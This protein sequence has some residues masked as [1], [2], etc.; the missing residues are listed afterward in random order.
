MTEQ[1]ALQLAADEIMRKDMLEKSSK[2]IAG[3]INRETP[4]IVNAQREKRIQELQEQQEAHIKVYKR[5]NPLIAKEINEILGLE[6]KE[7][8]EKSS[9]DNVMNKIEFSNK[10][11]RIYSSFTDDASKNV[12]SRGIKEV[13]HE[14]FVEAYEKAGNNVFQA[15]ADVNGCKDILELGEL[16]AKRDKE[17]MRAFENDKESIMIEKIAQRVAEILKESKKL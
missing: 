10:M 11:D 2:E 13:G 4:N 12:F 1:E 3:N 15:L 17:L 16:D 8:V 9:L 6:K 5:E 14:A 7:S